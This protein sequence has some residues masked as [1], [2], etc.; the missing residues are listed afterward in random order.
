M[1]VVRRLNLTRTGLQSSTSGVPSGTQLDVTG[2]VVTQSLP[3]S[4]A[5]DQGTNSP[6]A[7]DPY[8]GTDGRVYIDVRNGVDGAWATYLIT[9]QGLVNPGSTLGSTVALNDFAYNTSQGLVSGA[10]NFAPPSDTFTFYG[11]YVQDGSTFLAVWVGTSWKQIALDASA[12]TPGG[13]TVS[14]ITIPSWQ[15]GHLYTDEVTTYN[16]N[17]YKCVV[18]HTSG[19]SFDPTNWQAL[20]KGV[21]QHDQLTGINA[22]PAYQHVSTEQL[23]TIEALVARVA[24][25]EAQV[26][27]GT[28]STSTITVGNDSVLNGAADLDSHTVVLAKFL[29]V[30]A[31]PADTVTML[32]SSKVSGVPSSIL[33]APT[34]VNDQGAWYLEVPLQ[35]ISYGSSYSI[36]VGTGCVLVNGAFVNTN[37]VTCSF[38]TAT[39]PVQPVIGASVTNGAFNITPAAL[40]EIRFP[41]T[42]ASGVLALQIASPLA[43]SCSPA[44]VVSGSPSVDT[45]TNEIV[46]ALQGLQLDTQ[47]SLTVNSGAVSN[48]GYANNTNTSTCVFGTTLSVPVVAQAP[49]H[50]LTNIDPLSASNAF[51]FPL[52]TPTGLGKYGIDDATKIS[53]TGATAAGAS[54]TGNSLNVY[55][56]GGTEGTQVSAHVSAGAIKNYNT[57]GDKKVNATAVTATATFLLSVPTIGVPAI[58]GNQ[59]VAT[60]VGSVLVPYTSVTAATLDTAKITA[61]PANAIGTPSLTVSGPSTYISIPLTNAVN[62]GTVTVTMASNTVLNGGSVGNTGTQ[63]FAFRYTAVT[64][65]VSTPAISGSSVGAASV[66][67]V[68]FPVTAGAILADAS[69]ITMVPSSI[70]GSI[71]ITGGNIVVPVALAANNNYTISVAPGAVRIRNTYSA[72]TTTCVFATATNLTV[73]QSTTQGT[74]V[75]LAGFNVVFPI[76]NIN[77]A[78][79]LN[80]LTKI[81][82]TN[83][84]MGSPSISGATLVV[85]VSGLTYSSSVS[86]AVGVGAIKDAIV[87]N[88]GSVVCSFTTV[89]SVPTLGKPVQDG[90][91]T[92][93]AGSVTMDFPITAS[94]AVLLANAAG[95]TCNQ[96]G[97][98]QSVSVIGSTGAYK[99]RVVASTSNGVSYTVTVA[100]GV[101]TNDTTPSDTPVVTNF[102]VVDAA[103]IVAQ[104]STAGTYVPYTG[105]TTTLTYALTSSS[106]VTVAHASLI[107]VTGGPV[108]QSATV[109][110]TTLSVVLAS[111]LPN[112]TIA[113]TLAAGALRNTDTPTAVGVTTNF[114]TVGD[115]PVITQSSVNSNQSL[116]LTPAYIEYVVTASGP[117]SVSNA[118]AV[119][120]VPAG[121]VTS[122]SM[123]SGKLRLALTLGYNTSYTINIVAGLLVNTTTLS[124]T[125]LT[126]SFKTQFQAPVVG[127]SALN[128]TSNQPLTTATVV[129]PI[130]S[131]GTLSVVNALGV[132]ATNATVSSATISGSTL[133]VAITGLQ[134]SKTVTVT[135]GPNTVSNSDLLNTGTVTCSF[136]TA[137][138]I[139]TVGQSALDSTTVSKTGLAT[140]VFPVTGISGVLTIADATKVVATSGYPGIVTGASISGSNLVVAIQNSS[141]ADNTSYSVQVLPGAVKNDATLSTNTVTCAFATTYAAP[142]VGQSATNGLT[143]QALTTSSI[144]FPITTAGTASVLNASMV[145]ATNATVSAVTVVGATLVV[146]ITGLQNSKT[147]TVTVGAGTIKNRDASNTGSVTCSFTTIGS[148][149]VV[150]QSAIDSTTVSK[151]GL[152]SVSF[153]VTNVSGTLT[154]ADASKVYAGVG[155]DSI[156][157]GASI[158]GSN[159]V[160]SILNSSLNFNKPYRIQVDAG[161]VKND[162]VVN[163]NTVTCNFSTQAGVPV[164]GNASINGTRVPTT[165][166]TLTF[167]I[168]ASAVVGTYTSDASKVT[169]T[170]CTVTGAIISGSNLVVSI[171]GLGYSASASVVVG[172][173]AVKNSGI[174]SAASTTCA[175]TTVGAVVTIGQ[176]TINGSTTATSGAQDILFPLSASSFGTLSV[177]GL[178]VTMSPSVTSA[179]P[180]IVNQSGTNYLKVPVTL[181]ASTTY[182]IAISAGAV[183]NDTT[184]STS[185]VTCGFTTVAGGAGRTVLWTFPFTLPNAIYTFNLYTAPGWNHTL[186]LEDIYGPALDGNGGTAD[187]VFYGWSAQNKPYPNGTVVPRDSIDTFTPL[188]P[189]LAY[190][191]DDSTGILFFNSGSPSNKLYAVVKYAS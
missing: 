61:V 32:D 121:I 91:T 7:T 45:T 112:Q 66:T 20:S 188:N 143:A 65:I 120:S 70:S 161:A 78:A 22:D 81:V 39:A 40:T 163:T 47:Y 160:V 97:A 64:P 71:T 33:G 174:A 151:T 105:G 142:V 165:T 14:S 127:Q 5:V 101:V 191:W 145:S 73:Q 90:Q 179:T 104:S 102:K 42:V 6:Y 186:T 136:V 35:S 167:P 51:V 154:M 9:D 50:G 59:D 3:T 27:A 180:S 115:A 1:S 184:P 176:A 68:L 132:T 10:P 128:G 164:V 28:G 175:F 111:V 100:A 82:V 123:V 131:N 94:G 46:F 4:S 177:N 182:S 103:P 92:V 124:T 118:N 43:F 98:I 162:T 31:K 55:F 84:S 178:S 138:S 12:G 126:T 158:S 48:A 116:A 139:P 137:G 26:A 88:A 187:V 85:P 34:V 38:T 21:S 171:S 190:Q 16:N 168:T 133:V 53:V 130:T 166:T 29:I 24:V 157:T 146:A 170:G 2:A 76:A 80:D 141:L 49:Q 189:D 44:N 150:G 72:V 148:V 13:S 134:N 11:P 106:P 152:V 83:A 135:V 89:G 23:A 114:G 144:V 56:T 62:D 41:V 58:N 147:V 153:P 159:L 67:Q 54:I 109:S 15:P 110:G 99:L 19:F 122:V 183:I 57:L 173:G 93:S 172:A 69:K 149:P 117:V 36:T 37:T 8:V 169:S 125:T 52:S 95:V 113:V 79:V 185:S 108:V 86:V 74:R 63:N 181:A 60:S 156:V 96:A 75:P 30:G 17:L 155:F 87:S 25:L 107:T 77:G 140:I 18:I 129:F 119:T